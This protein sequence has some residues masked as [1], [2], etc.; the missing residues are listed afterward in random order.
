MYKLLTNNH[1]RCQSEQAACAR[2]PAYWIHLDMNRSTLSLP[3]DYLE[4]KATAIL[5][6]TE[7]NLSI[8]RKLVHN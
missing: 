2:L 3:N 1:C 7:V 5:C 8:A 4:M 6:Y